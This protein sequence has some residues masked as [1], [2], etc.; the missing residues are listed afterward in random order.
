MRRGITLL[1]AGLFAVGMLGASEALAQSKSAPPA[2]TETKAAPAAKDD[3]KKAHEPIDIN[4]ATADELKTIPGIGDAYSKK[5]VDGRPYKRKDDLKTKKIVPDATY[6][7][8]KDHVVAKQ[9][10]AAKT[11]KKK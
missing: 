1:V 6:E 8:I 9:D 7:K 4:S 3:A 2:K 10:T 11:D 5:I